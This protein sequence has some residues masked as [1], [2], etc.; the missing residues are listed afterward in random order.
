MSLNLGSIYEIFV[1]EGVRADVRSKKQIQLS[2]R[3][4]KVEFN[5][6]SASA[7]KFFDK[8]CFSNPYAD[9][10]I[11]SGNSNHEVKRVLVGIDVEIGE[12]L[13]A[14]Q[15]SKNGKKIDLVLAHHPEGVALAGLSDVM[16]LQADIFHGLGIDQSVAKDLMKQRIGEVSRSIHGANHARSVDA[17]K[18]LG[19]PFMC[20]HTPADNHVVQY[21][22]MLVNKTKPKT[23]K[24]VIDLLLKEPEYRDAASN[25]A[26][27]IILVGDPKKKA[28]KIFVDMTGGTSG[29]KDVFA[30]MSQAGVTTMIAMHLSEG[31]FN[32]IK[33]EHINVIIAGHMASDN[34]G[35]N[36]LLDKVERQSKGT[37]AI[38]ECSGFRRI[39]R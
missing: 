2:L 30:R 35:M 19:L 7:R 31:H 11:L 4:K 36:L 21:L 34:L 12:L 15:L 20:C 22:Q 25:K 32:K 8:E 27:P 38:V 39:K 16:T 33:K 17:A 9:T 28:G 26:G 3:Q 18:L 1:R 24:S 5:K 37:V 23:L 14:D 6:L 13:L 29:P 10:R